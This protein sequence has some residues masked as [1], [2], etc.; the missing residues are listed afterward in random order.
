VI[1]P[2]E[3]NIIGLEFDLPKQLVHYCS[4]LEEYISGAIGL[5]PFVK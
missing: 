3:T 1:L 2:E 5:T 4:S